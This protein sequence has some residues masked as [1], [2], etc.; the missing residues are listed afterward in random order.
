MST[1]L[2][3]AA[4]G[5]VASHIVQQLVTLGM[6]VRAAVRSVGKAKLPPEVELVEFD[7][8]RPD[9]VL[10]AFAGVERAFLAT[11]LVPN[12]VELDQTCVEAAKANNVQHL[13]K[14]SVMGADSEPDMLLG[15][16]HF[17]S[18]QAIAQSGL[19]YTILR[20]NSFHQNYITYCSDTIKSQNAFYLPLGE[21]R[22]SLVDLRDVAAVAGAVLTQPIANHVGKAYQV[23]GATALSNHE[24]AA[25]L[26]E[27]LNRPIQ[28]VDV[29]ESAARE[30]MQ[31]AG[32]PD[33]QIDMVLG[34]YAQ[35]KAGHYSAI[36]PT[37]EALTGHTPIPFAQ[38]AQDYADR[39]VASS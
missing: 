6:Q 28:Y 22:L 3:T 24:V 1:I 27:V 10:A 9:T 13:V 15:Q 19:A 35:Q 25:I 4:T 14:L 2:V 33:R 11:P 20:P 39:F 31:A 37:V 38:F 5:N 26:S 23:T 12:L 8:A 29:P 18:E 32:A 7:L 17:K 30:A 34:L 16:L 36:A 21:G